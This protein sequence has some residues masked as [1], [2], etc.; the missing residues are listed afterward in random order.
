MILVIDN[1][2]SFTY[3]LVQYLGELAGDQEI[4]VYRN[5]Q[6]KAAEILELNP[7]RILLSPGP[8]NPDGAGNCLEIVRQLK[9]GIPLLGVC[10][11]HQVIGQAFGGEIIAA[12]KLMHGKVSTITH[13]GRELFAD[14]PP[15]FEAARYH[16]LVVNPANL[17]PALT[18]TARSEDGEIMGLKHYQE[19]IWGIQFHPESVLTAEGKKILSN[20]LYG[21]ET[22]NEDYRSDCCCYRAS[23][24]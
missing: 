18:V 1:Y 21:K 22:S 5:D 4:A 23:R 7:Q 16:S 11:G 24:A 2:D 6:I 19:P 8:G 10:L 15:A 9:G 12:G 13:N 3:N 17:P 14:L 20:F